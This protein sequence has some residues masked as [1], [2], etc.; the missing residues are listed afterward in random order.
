M[1][2]GGIGGY[3]AWTTPAR[4]TAA[5][6]AL[7]AANARSR[8]ADNEA[9]Q[10]LGL[11]LQEFRSRFAEAGRVVGTANHRSVP[12]R[13][14]LAASGTRELSAAATAATMRA[15]VA[16]A[17]A[18]ASY[19]PQDPDW[20]LATRSAPTLGGTYDGS[21]GDQTLT[22]NVTQGGVVGQDALSLAVL[23]AEGSLL[24]TLAVAADYTAGDDIALSNGV[25]M[26]LAAGLVETGN[27]F[28]I[29]VSATA[30]DP[31]S[32]FSPTDATWALDA[33]P[34]VTLGGTYDGSNGN[35]RLT[36]S[37]STGGTVGSD[38]LVVDVLDAGGETLEQ[39]NIADSYT[40]GEAITLANGV[41][42]SLA[43]GYL[44][45][46]DTFGVDVAATT[47]ETQRTFTPTDPTWSGGSSAAAT[48]GGSYDGSNGSQALTYRVTGAGE[49]GVD[50]LTLQVLDAEGSLLEELAVAS[51]YVAGTALTLANG[52]TLSLGSG[53]LEDGD[54]FTV[55]VAE[56]AGATEYSYAAVA[57]EWT[58]AARSSATI[59]GTYDG[60]NGSQQ[61][62]LRVSTAGVVGSSEAVIDLLDA[63]GTVISQVTVAAGYTPGEALDLGNGLTLA[64]GAGALGLG[65]EFTLDVAYDA[66]SST[67]SATA[68]TA[69]WVTGPAPVATVGGTYDGS[70]GSQALTL[71]VTQGG[72]V[73][74]DE[75]LID[76]LDAEGSLL[77][78]LTVASD[79][80]AGTDIALA[81]GMTVSLAAGRAGTG[82]AFAV[83]VTEAQEVDT[84]AAFDG[85][86]GDAPAWLQGAVISDGSF[87]LNDVEIA[88]YAADSLD[89]VLARINEADA[90]VTATFGADG[91]LL[92]TQ[93]TTGSAADI[94]VAD[95]TSGFLAAFGLDDAT[96][97]AG[98]DGDFD[99]P[100]SDLAA[101]SGL[102]SGTITVNGTEIDIDVDEDSLDDVIASLGA[103]GLTLAY[104]DAS[105]KFGLRGRGALSLDDGD[106]GFFASL[107]LATGNYTDARAAAGFASPDQVTTILRG[108]AADW[109]RA[110]ATEYEGSAAAH[111]IRLDGALRKALE[112]Q[113]AASGLAAGGDTLDTG[114]GL[115]FHFGP[116]GALEL[117]VDASEL[118]LAVGR[119]A[120]D[121]QR[122]LTGSDGKGGLL[123]ALDTALQAT[124]VA[125]DSVL[126]VRGISALD[127]YA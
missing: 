6:N 108:L 64:L 46:G 120:D 40:P 48:I 60:A 31:T 122:F 5:R 75:I 2:V 127:V 94:T 123:A 24:E 67:G 51:D 65:D 114:L 18:E 99:A 35:Q 125:V 42:V 124:G 54:T 79:Y 87:L 61:L 116:D 34:E 91:R 30:T 113:F 109:N 36:L 43:A 23:D 96:T 103:V 107:G 56:T 1:R 86:G 22:V 26:Q 110:R 118:A 77:E 16:I 83:T 39:L 98:S 20:T 111:V 32:S 45:A 85:G 9:L 50:A 106:T 104:D 29:D 25:T 82:D 37:V 70:N 81:N 126:R 7:A 68:D 12:G 95:D 14:H 97:T 17:D 78:Q 28:T 76:V 117:A 88:V 57:A 33:R 21:N 112:Q 66:G 72:T 74:A 10:G 93:A 47:G 59:A 63:E 89:T 44:A 4:A 101:L 41:T 105:G 53:V 121:L 69:G 73:G 119:K 8:T 100:L 92:L 38:A 115:S 71:Q 15:T 49:V 19:S 3:M 84:A 52:L 58:T 55:D 80:E 13:F 90:G 11:F 27:T 102:E 62:T